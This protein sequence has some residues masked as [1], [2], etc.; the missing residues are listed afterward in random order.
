MEA[1][2]PAAHRPDVPLEEKRTLRVFNV[3]IQQLNIVKLSSH[4]SKFG[5][6][7][8]EASKH[9]PWEKAPTYDSSL[10]DSKK[11]KNGRRGYAFDTE[12]GEPELL[13]TL[14]KSSAAE[15]AAEIL[16]K[17]RLAQIAKQEQPRPILALSWG[18]MRHAMRRRNHPY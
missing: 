8:N 10:D 17:Q 5:N 6:V 3:P 13:G 9:K 4:F 1:A 14:R 11:N 7:V 12:T 18:V 15:R 2:A 16:A